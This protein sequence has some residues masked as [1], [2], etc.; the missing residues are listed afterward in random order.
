MWFERLTGF[1]ERSAVDVAGRFEV[2]GEWLIS[3]ANGRRIR[4]G[5]FEIA[6]LTELRKRREP[7]WTGH[8]LRLDQ[9]VADVQ[10][11]TALPAS[12]GATFQVASQ[13]NMLEMVSPDVTPER[14]V[15]GYE[16][17]RTQGPACAIACGAGTIYRNYFVPIDDAMGQTA[18][19]QLNGLAD[20]AAALGVDVE[21]R[22]GYA[23]PTVAQL[24]AIAAQVDGAD[25]TARDR[26]MGR[27]RVG[28]QWSTE[29]TLADAGHTVTQVYCSALP[30][31][32]T[33][34]AADLWEP[35]GRLVLDAAYEATFAVAAANAEQTGNADLYLTMLGAGAFG[36]PVEW[37]LASIER[38]RRL[39]ANDSL[40]VHV[41]SY[42]RRR[43]EVDT[44]TERFRSWTDPLFEVPPHQWGQRGDPHLWRELQ[45]ALAAHPQPGS[46][47]ELAALI[48]RELRRLTGVDIGTTTETA[49]QIERY[50]TAGMSGGFVSPPTW[51][52]RMVPLLTAR[53]DAR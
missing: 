17:D 36:N 19:R 45:A 28:V 53:F 1:D 6:S 47:P 23:L 41:V 30:V 37:V 24:R 18:T 38:A 52:D 16:H 42:G 40:D 8:G 50:P 7:H 21:M 13:F 20:L 15:D 51:R 48:A 35:F 49:V 5:R 22:N 29:V 11:L 2:D 27:V 25:E 12:A 44:I 26:L 43:P 14:G 39:Y 46:T 9:I 32:Y 10:S 31:A 3:R 33:S 34:I 4:A